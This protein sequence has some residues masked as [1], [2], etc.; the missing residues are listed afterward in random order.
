MDNIK[1]GIMGL[2]FV[3]GAIKNAYDMF[4]VHT[5]CRDPL[6]GFDSTI[7]DLL[8][9]DGIFISV[10]SPQNENGSCDSSILESV[11]E[12]L[13]EYKNVIISKVTAP[14]NVYTSLIKKYPNLVH[15]P[16]FLIASTANEDYLTGQF[17]IIGGNEVYCAQAL[18]IIKLGQRQITDYKYCSIEEAS[19]TKYAINCFLST[20]VVF[21]NQLKEIADSSNADFDVIKECI[22]L[23]SRLG[24]SHFDVPGPDGQ[25]GFG[26]ACFPKDTSALS[27]YSK[28]IG[29]DFTLLNK[30]ININKGL[31][32]D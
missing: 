19:L 16:E 9:T 8:T 15:A 31:R 32:N 29:K 13:K 3:G 7:D 4:N 6:K 17:S 26:G 5:V 30:A 23:D 18:K 14:P 11:L 28:L 12:E 21:M 2:G 22:K 20:K 10:P 25:Y 24:H 1:I 27:Y